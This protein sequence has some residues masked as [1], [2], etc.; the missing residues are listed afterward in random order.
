[1]SIVLLKMFVHL[2]C[3]LALAV[4]FAAVVGRL[5]MES[6]MA[7][8]V[9]V[10]IGLISQTGMVPVSDIVVGIGWVQKNTVFAEAG[11]VLFLTGTMHP[12]TGISFPPAGMV[13]LPA[14]LISRMTGI[15]AEVNL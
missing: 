14:G 8:M 5:K 3:R 4:G 12:M 1:V 15:V 2:D 11:I 9:L 6:L 10:Q 13:L 7:D